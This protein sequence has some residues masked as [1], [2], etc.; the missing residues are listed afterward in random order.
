[1]GSD[2]P[3]FLHGGTSLVTGRGEFI[4]PLPD[5]EPVWYGLVKPDISVFTG[6]VFGSLS[7][8]EWTDGCR[9]HDMVAEICERRRV[10]VGINGLQ[11]TVFRRYPE[12]RACFAAME[13]AAPGRTFM[14]GS[15][16]TMGALC[17]SRREAEQVVAAATR[18]GWWSA[19]ARSMPAT[20]A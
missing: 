4:K 20:A 9:T 13:A 14:S 10:A 6:D 1:M 2:V 15:G 3:F 5:P 19:V 11:E 7:P 12:A 8:H 16:P 17:T 18:P